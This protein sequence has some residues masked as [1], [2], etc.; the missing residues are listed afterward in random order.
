M[1]LFV[2]LNQM[3]LEFKILLNM[4]FTIVLRA[5]LNKISKLALETVLLTEQNLQ[6]HTLV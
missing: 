3:I 1:S 4:T 6:I 2:I 5:Q